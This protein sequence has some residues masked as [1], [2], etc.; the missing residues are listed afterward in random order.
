M[1]FTKYLHIVFFIA[2]I[3][4]KAAALPV[5]LCHDTCDGQIEDCELC[6][7]AIHSQSIVFSP[8]AQLKGPEIQR[9]FSF[10]PPESC[11]KSVCVIRR[12][13]DTHFGRPP[14]ASGV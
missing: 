11:Y 4:L 14:P 13:N 7:H 3:A 6:E 5:Y 10:R 9:S 1:A 12:I 8:P 2:L